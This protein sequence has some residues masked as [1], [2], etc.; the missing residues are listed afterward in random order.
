MKRNDKIDSFLGNDS[1]FEGKLIFSGTTRIDGNFRGEIET[2]G[3]LLIGSGGRVHAD[4][5][6]G[7]VVCSGE[8]HGR[9]VVEKSIEVHVP[10]K[11]YG[12]IISPKVMIQEGVIFEGNCRTVR[13][14]TS[15]GGNVVDMAGEKSKKT[16]GKF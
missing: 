15:G 13:G 1:T 4:I 16:L 10:G 2:D 5:K 9:L 8:I 3:N 14:D 12:D 7:T 6:A 11:I